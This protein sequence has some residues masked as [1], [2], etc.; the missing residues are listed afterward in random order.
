MKKILYILSC[1]LLLSLG[2][3]VSFAEVDT[4]V[5][6]SVKMEE[7]GNDTMLRPRILPLP[8]VLINASNTP[9]REDRERT[10]ERVEVRMENKIP[11]NNKEDV[12]R[13]VL[14]KKSSTTSG[15]P[16]EQ[17]M[18]RVMDKNFGSTT[19]RSEMSSTTKVRKPENNRAREM[20]NKF[21]P[22]LERFDATAIRLTT[23]LEKVQSRIT[24]IKENGGNSTTA[25]A[26]VV[27]AQAHLTNAKASIN[28]L[29]AAVEAN[30]RVNA[31]ASTT[32]KTIKDSLLNLQ[33]TAEE[34]KKHLEEGRHS[35]EKAVQALREGEKNNTATTTP[36]P[37]ENRANTGHN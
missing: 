5:N 28:T 7:R 3:Q 15:K 37:R 32:P 31:G 33:K 36:N 16:L 21:A 23:I 2:T 35:I 26:F 12:Q 19:P 18:N 14:E 34:T 29:K 24:K 30:T 27:E 9:F 13:K 17:P 10:G 11:L 1:A 25:E 20:R 22:M 6:T 8:P 4:S